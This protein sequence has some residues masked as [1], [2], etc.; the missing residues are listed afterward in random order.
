MANKAAERAQVTLSFLHREEN[1]SQKIFQAAEQAQHGAAARAALMAVGFGN[2][3]N[4]KYFLKKGVLMTCLCFGI[5]GW[6]LIGPLQT[7]G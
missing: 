5:N 4:Q 3:I 2:K 7:I 6:K 1:I